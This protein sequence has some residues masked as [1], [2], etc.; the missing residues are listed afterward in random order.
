MVV[1]LIL[2][3]I[4]IITNQESTEMRSNELELDE[5][6]ELLE[7]FLIIDL[8]EEEEEEKEI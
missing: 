1:A 5:E 6:D 8:L 2:G 7:E 4:L 3:F